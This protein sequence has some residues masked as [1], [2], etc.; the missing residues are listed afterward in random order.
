MLFRSTKADTDHHGFGTGSIVSTAE[1]YGGTV[2][3]SA[4]G[5][6]YVLRIVFPA[7]DADQGEKMHI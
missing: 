2:R 1:Q 6:M 5:G 4:E 7:P 3:I